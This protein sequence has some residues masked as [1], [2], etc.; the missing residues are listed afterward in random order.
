MCNHENREAAM[1]VIDPGTPER[2]GRDGV[3]CDPCLEPLVRALNDAGMKTV[4]SCCG[5]GGNDSSV[6]LADGRWIVLTDR[7]PIAYEYREPGTSTE[8]QE[9]R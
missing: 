5:H 9:N 1:V 8:G 7:P 2:H 3:W 4:A 6:A